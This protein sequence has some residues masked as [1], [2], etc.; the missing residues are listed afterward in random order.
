M[1]RERR[2][3]HRRTEDATVRKEL[4]ELRQQL[5]EDSGQKELRRKRRRAIRHI[6]KVHIALRIAHATGD[7][8]D[9][10]LNEYPIKGRILDLSAEGCSVFTKDQ[11]DMGQELNLAIS[12]QNGSPIRTV[13]IVRWTKAIEA[14]NGF[15]AGVQFVHIEDKGPK[16]IRKFLDTLDATAGL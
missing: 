6:C 5:Q 15:A 13:S 2:K 8:H 14:K 7:S 16:R 4:A 11:L 9:W 10:V 1:F 3:Q 12:L